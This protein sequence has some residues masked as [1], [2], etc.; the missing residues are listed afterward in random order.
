MKRK[1]AW[2]IV[3]ALII[4]LLPAASYAMDEGEMLFASESVKGAVGDI[5]KVDFY[6]YPNL[7]EGELMDSLELSL[8]YDPEMLTFGSLNL[9]DEEQNLSSLLYGKSAQPPIYNTKEP[10]V[11]VLAWAELYGTDQQGFL[12]QVEFR[13]EKE[14]ASTFL[15]N[16]VRY[17]TINGSNFQSIGSYFINPVQIGGVYTEGYEIVDNPEPD[18]TY[19][20][21]EPV[22]ETPKPQ[23]TA[24][25]KPSNSGHNVPQTSTLPTPSNLPTA[26]TTGIVTPKPA[27]TSM[28]MTTP[29]GTGTSATAPASDPLQSDAPNTSGQPSGNTDVETTN[30]P[31]AQIDASAAPVPVAEATVNPDDGKTVQPTPAS[32]DTDSGILS[33]RALVIAVIAGIVVVILLAAL[34]IVLVL[35]RNKRQRDA[36]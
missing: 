15:F 32:Q 19:E 25:P 20:P 26:M 14:G 4:A 30:D 2:L 22:V 8:Y 36:E 21:L 35:I 18:A 12:F 9:R 34:A 23:A 13:V 3:F 24:T 27:V 33:N 28:P 16:S 29:S 10:G 7:T 17:H 5:I 11:I 6:C 31:N 1:L